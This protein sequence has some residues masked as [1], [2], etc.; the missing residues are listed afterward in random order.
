M[1]TRNK[2]MLLCLILAEHQA[3]FSSVLPLLPFLPVHDMLW[4][5]HRYHQYRGATSPWTKLTAVAVMQKIYLIL[6]FTQRNFQ[7]FNELHGNLI[8]DFQTRFVIS[9]EELVKKFING[10]ISGG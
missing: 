9:D 2:I 4:A 6:Q 1:L 8:K 3:K 7:F 5:I 10:T